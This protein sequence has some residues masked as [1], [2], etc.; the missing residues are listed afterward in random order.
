MS[1]REIIAAGLL[2]AVLPAEGAPASES[3]PLG[4]GPEVV[5]AGREIY[6]S[7]CTVCHGRDGEA[8]DRAPALA[9]ARAYVRR[10]EKE[11]FDAIKNG[12]PGTGMPATGLSDDDVWRV[13]AYV[14]SLRATAAD[15]PPEGDAEA[16][17]RLFWGKADCG[18]CH[19]VSGRGGLL[20][21]DLT[22]L[23]GRLTVKAIREALTVPKPRAPRGYEPAVIR[24]AA[25]ETLTGVLK[26]RHNFS[27]QLLDRAGRL[28][29]LS[30]DEVANIEI[31]EKSLMP[32]D[33]DRRLTKNEF[34]DLLAYLSRLT[35]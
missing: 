15:F 30:P 29:M 21:P 12:I 4:N 3:N 13:V 19:T 11:L 10:S 2:L 34:R 33:V 23:G 22:D 8:G 26:N 17:E 9:A 14:R 27:F 25:G 5:A 16:G 24:T 7:G 1:L 28:H 20:G 18:D 6:N 35:R 31:G 32:V